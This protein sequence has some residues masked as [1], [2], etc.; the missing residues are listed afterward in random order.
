MT[1]VQHREPGA[2][3]PIRRGAMAPQHVQME[4]RDACRRLALEYPGVKPHAIEALMDQALSRTLN[5]SIE[6]FRVVL[7]ERSTRARLR[8]LAEDRD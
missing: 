3:M 6:S 8:A 4:A 2:V 7:A 5:A 1:A